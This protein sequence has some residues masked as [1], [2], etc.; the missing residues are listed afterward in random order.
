MEQFSRCFL[1]PVKH[2]G[3]NNLLHSTNYV[4]I[5]KTGCIAEVYFYKENPTIN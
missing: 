1:P 3:E 4:M 2:G 5:F